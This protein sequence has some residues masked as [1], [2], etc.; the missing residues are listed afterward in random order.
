[1]VTIFTEHTRFINMEAI[2]KGNPKTIADPCCNGYYMYFME[3]T[4]RG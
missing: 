4:Y 3:A 2:L 1:M